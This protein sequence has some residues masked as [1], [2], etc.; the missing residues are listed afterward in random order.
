[1]RVIVQLAGP[2]YGTVVMSPESTSVGTVVEKGRT[3]KELSRET[4]TYTTSQKA[5][6]QKTRTPSVFIA[7]LNHRAE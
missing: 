5:S 7:T 2:L 1:M 4:A 3:Q 6:V